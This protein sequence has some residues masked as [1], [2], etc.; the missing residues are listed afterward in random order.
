M[1]EISDF[2]NG[3]LT[4]LIWDKVANLR[5]WDGAWPREKSFPAVLYL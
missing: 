1:Q 4:G 2:L 3:L 5:K